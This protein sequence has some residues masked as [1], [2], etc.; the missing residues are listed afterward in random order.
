MKHDL[1]PRA[2]VA[3]LKQGGHSVRDA[4]RIIHKPKSFV[5]RWWNRATVVDRHGGGKLRRVTR[6]LIDKVKKQMELKQHTS[7]RSVARAMNLSQTSVVK[8]VHGA[9]LFPYHRWKK[10][11]LSKKDVAKRLAWAKL[12]RNEDWSRVMFTDEKIVFCVPHTNS[13]NDII[14]A[15]K[16]TQVLPAP[17]DRHSAKMNVSVSIWLDGRSEIHIFTENLVKELYVDILKQTILPAFKKMAGG[18][19]KLLLD[20]DPKHTSHLVKDFLGHTHTAH[21]WPPPRSPCVNCAENVWPILMSELQKLGLQTAASLR[22]NIKKAWSNIPQNSIRN[23][24]LSMSKRCQLI[25]EAKGNH[26]KY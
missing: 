10:L 4:A 23:C 3:A 9:G 6:S 16:G 18:G 20:N 5:E 14:W 13:K 22:K 19:G 11:I 12:H 17:H 15:E 21:I 24:V 2:Q 1:C 26:I 8:A 7:T 25:I